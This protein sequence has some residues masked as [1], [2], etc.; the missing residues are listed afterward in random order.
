[1][2]R[3]TKIISVELTF[4]LVVINRYQGIG[5]SYMQSEGRGTDRYFDILMNISVSSHLKLRMGKLQMKLDA[6]KHYKMTLPIHEAVVLLNALIIEES[7]QSST[8]H[9]RMIIEK[10]KDLLTKQLI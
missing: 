5:Q 7:F 10:Y 8:P 9:E 6:P 4:L 2:L 3:I 1:M